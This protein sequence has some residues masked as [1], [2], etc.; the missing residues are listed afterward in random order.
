MFKP[1]PFFEKHS[2]SI[3][4]YFEDCHSYGEWIN[5]DLTLF[6]SIKDNSII[7]VEITLSME[8]L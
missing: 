4:W 2:N 8:E 6:R 5:D 1:F 7:G 3:I